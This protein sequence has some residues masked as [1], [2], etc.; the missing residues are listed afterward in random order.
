[1]KRLLSL[2]L[3]QFLIYNAAWTQTWT[4]IQG[5]G[6]DIESIHWIDD[7]TGV[8]VGERLIIRTNDK[9]ETWNEVLQ[10]FDDHFMDLEFLSPS[11]GIAVGKN[12]TLYVTSDAGNT[13]IKKDPGI[14]TDLLSIEKMTGNQLMVTGE[15]GVII[16]SPDAG[17]TWSKRSSGTTLN[18]NEVTFINSDTAFIVADEGTILY[19]YDKGVTWSSSVV[20]TNM[21]LYGIVFDSE[22]I[23]YAVGENGLVLKTLDTGNNWTALNSTV[24]QD[25]RKV[26]ISPLDSK[27]VL[28]VGD[29]GTLIRSANSGTIF[30]KINLGATITRSI[31]D[32]AFK[33]GLG[34]VSAIGQDGYL[35]NS[36]NSGAT[37]IQKFA[38]IRNDFTSVDFKNQNTGFI[39]GQNGAVLLTSNG[40]VTITNRPL[41]EP[42]LIHAIDFWNTSFGYASSSSGKVY[43]TGNSGVSWLP[44]SLPVDKTLSGFYLFAPSVLYAAGNGGYLTRSFD[45]GMTWD[46][47]VISNTSENLRD[48][49]FFDFVT[50][51]AIGENGQIS[52]SAG[53]N[54]WQ[55]IPKVTT[56][57]LNGLAKLDTTRALIVGDAGIILKTEDKAK[58]WRVIPSGTTKNLNSIDFFGESIGLIAGDE[59]LAMVTLDG[60]ETWIQTATGTLRDLSAVSAGTDSKAY[61]VGEDGT[62]IS[63]NCIP[64]VGSLGQISGNSQSCVSTEI[65]QVSELPLSG[66]EIIWRVDGGEIISGQGTHRVEVK[67]TIPGRNAVLVSRAN[68]CGS[69]ETS[70]LEVLVNSLPSTN[71]Q[72]AGDGIGC[73]ESTSVYS[74]PISEETT[75]TWTAT[76][77]D[78]LS[79]QGTNEILIRWQQAGNQLLSVTQEN[80]CGKIIPLQKA[81]R[82]NAAPDQPSN[83]IGEKQTA[84]GEQEY[85]V[86]EIS[87]LDYRWSISGGGKILSGQ[88][89]A[90]VLVRWE[91]EGNFD[92]TVEAQ[93][94]CGFGQNRSLAVNVNFITAIE[95][96]KRV[97]L[98][99]YPNPSLGSITVASDHLDSWSKIT[100][101]NPLGQ[102]VNSMMIRQGETAIYFNG[103][104]T[105]M[106]LVVL[107][108]KSD[109]V[110]ESVIVR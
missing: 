96:D 24:T 57:D 26:R 90:R 44:V 53:G 68:F 37:W 81:I 31:K 22:G 92:L 28:A 59:G 21:D 17:N 42:I 14:S 4:R 104:P 12:G 45:S 93:N 107:E 25:L 16:Y 35:I 1:M 15:N 85:E 78:I 91:Q 56:K 29:L 36:I 40:G 47:M 51:F 49:T 99:I 19:S 43:R 62:I 20:A 71:L 7:L 58:T 34:L 94:E 61:F 110:R 86:A 13:W 76:G 75:Y 79:G 5:W 101:F 84:L 11:V 3:F 108:G 89:A 54:E 8:A 18:L 83:I 109:L 66:S 74:I 6:L 102:Q 10:Q 80:R 38:G 46:Q 33:P 77:G 98:K 48:V 2:F 41:P 63:Y 69:G 55:N 97:E 100:V 73:K 9:G 50:G 82:I 23:G 88:G 95:P 106:L 65:Y 39:S 70:A 32:L 60:G 105:G 52:W 27:V 67:W 72:I 64:P 103:L 30:S 87:G